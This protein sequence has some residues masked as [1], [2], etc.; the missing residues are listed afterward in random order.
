MHSYFASELHFELINYREHCFTQWKHSNWTPLGLACTHVQIIKVSVLQE[1][2][3]TTSYYACR[4]Q[5]LK[6]ASVEH[7]FTHIKG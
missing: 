3:C 6:Q 7:R 5:K 4:E 2:K 1:L